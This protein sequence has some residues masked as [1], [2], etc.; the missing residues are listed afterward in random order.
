MAKQKTNSDLFIPTI[1]PYTLFPFSK[2]IVPYIILG[3]IGFIFYI[4]TIKNEF[5]LDDGIVIHKNEYVME[6]IGGIDSIMKRD[7][8]HSFYKQMNAKAQLAG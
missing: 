5:A 8:Y 1:N 7:A 3:L 6:G 2:P 4:N